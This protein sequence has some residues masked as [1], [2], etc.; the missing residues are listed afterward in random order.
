MASKKDSSRE[1]VRVVCRIR[2]QNQKESSVG[3][4]QCVRHTNETIEVTTEDGLYNFSFD[5]VFGPEST[6][7][8]IFDHTAVPLIQDVL[9]GYNS[10][11]FAYGQ[12]RTIL[13]SL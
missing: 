12:V 5:Q 8:S 2:P 13:H 6:Q 3:G 1:N 4:F 11:I 7:A 9:N 10:T